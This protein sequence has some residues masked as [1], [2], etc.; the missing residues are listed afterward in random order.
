MSLT[1]TRR[2]HEARVIGE[3]SELDVRIFSLASFFG[4]PMFAQV[5]VAEQRR[6]RAQHDAM[7][8]YCNILV[9]RIEAFS[10]VVGIINLDNPGPRGH[11]NVIELNPDL[12]GQ[13]VFKEEVPI[14][15]KPIND[16]D[17]FAMM[18]DHWHAKGIEKGNRLLEI[19]EG[20]SV[21]LVDAKNPTEVVAMDLTGPYLQV[22]KVGAMAVLNVFKDLPFGA[23]I[24]EAPEIAT[25]D[26][27]AS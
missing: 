4:S 17:T 5:D 24:E 15:A 26:S 25:D 21:E 7:V 18:V 10:P 14:G 20:T 12:A 3:K 23:S 22:F 9:E 13:A 2:P 27:A 19:P 6:L 1:P 16:I 11:E 8:A